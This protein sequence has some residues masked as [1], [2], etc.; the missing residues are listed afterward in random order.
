L[1]DNFAPHFEE[2]GRRK[3]RKGSSKA[4]GHRR[5]EAETEGVGQFL[6]IPDA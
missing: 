3:I 5:E 1:G 6:Q 4:K 2:T